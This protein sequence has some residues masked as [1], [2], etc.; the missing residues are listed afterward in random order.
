MIYT[1]G[2]ANGFDESGGLA[3]SMT[4]PGTK[5]DGISLEMSAFRLDNFRRNPMM[6]WQHGMDPNRG[7][8]PI[9]KWEGVR[10]TDGG[11]SGVAVFD[12]ED[13]FA[14]DLK[15]KFQRGFLN[16]VSIGWLPERDA[17]G[18]VTYD[19]LEASAVA[20]PADPSALAEGRAHHISHLEA[21]FRGSS[22]ASRLSSIIDG[23]VTDSRPRSEIIAAMASAAGISEST[24][25]QILNGGIDC[26]PRERLS[27]FAEA[28]SVS[29]SSL[30]SA[31][32][33]DGC[34]YSERAFAE[35]AREALANT[36]PTR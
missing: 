12:G 7:S 26:P 30:I 35:R 2:L 32:E 16:A 25:N 22:L 10:H 15:S 29:L 14:M 34:T 6:L 27:G 8:V 28:L 13:S 9:G 23:K 24:V 4:T 17:D 20:V 1:R 18:E 11:I 33:S 21:F 31:A 36:I 19:L 3:F 5:R